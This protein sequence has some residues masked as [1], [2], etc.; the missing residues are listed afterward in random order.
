MGIPGLLQLVA[1]VTVP[2]HVQQLAGRRVA[3]DSYSWL[4]K[5]AYACAQQL[6]Q[7]SHTDVYCVLLSSSHPA[8][9]TLFPFLI[10]FL[11]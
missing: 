6:V 9:L 10:S 11:W 1:P 8:N 2:V 5:G 7:G 4:H 3:I